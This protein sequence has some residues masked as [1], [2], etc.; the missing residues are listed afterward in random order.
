MKSYTELNIKS[1]YES[2]I[3]NI[4]EDFYEPVLS[5]SISYDR[6]AGFFS[7][8]SLALVAQGMGEF[9]CNGGKM[10]L[11]CSPVLSAQDAK[12]IKDII[13]SGKDLTNEIS[14]DIDI[15]S[16]SFEKD[17]VKALGWMLSRG[18]LEIRLAILT[19]EKG[20]VESTEE[21]LKN[22]L[23][24]QKVGILSDNFGNTLSFSGSINESASAWGKNDEEFKV[25]KSWNSTKE[26]LIKD[27]NK[28][29]EYWNSKRK[30]V[31]LFTLPKALKD[32][33]IIFAKDFEPTSIIRKK[34]RL[35]KFE[36]SIPL[37]HYQNTALVQWKKNGFS[38]LFEM[39]TGTGKTRTALAGIDYL[40]GL[41]K[42]IITVISTPQSTLSLQ[43]KSELEKL[44]IEGGEIVI[45]D[46]NNPKWFMQLQKLLLRQQIGMTDK[47][48]IYTTHDTSSSERFTKLIQQY[49]KK[50]NINLFIGDEAHWLGAPSLQKALLPKY[51]YR[52]GLSA[53]PSRWFD[54]D[55]TSL[56]VNYFG[57]K[58]FEF[59]I[60]QALTE[61]NPL[62]KKHF[63]VNYYYYI[64]KVPLSS[65]ETWKYKNETKKIISLKSRTKHDEKA[66]ENYQRAL[67][68]RAKIIKNAESKYQELKKI[69]RDIIDKGKMENLI[70]FVSPEQL[71]KVSDILLNLNIPF[72]KLTQSEGT[73]PKEKYGFISE[74]E[75]IIK[76]F[77]EKL[78]KALIA[79]KC[80][81]EGIDIP[82]AS[83]G[84]L[85]ASNTNPR[86]YIQRIGRIIRQSEDKE[87]AYLYDLCV[88]TSLDYD[89]E[90]GEFEQ[91]IRNKEKIRMKEIAKNAI[92][93]A[94]ALINIL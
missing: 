60:E 37:F 46:G 13:E 16:N 36:T 47:I 65:E 85:M 94:E 31:K 91:A 49:L 12:I 81:D 59:T 86:E 42:N 52:I 3:D 9:L 87:C 64:H 68:R 26:Y 6:I 45:A 5:C 27:N 18:L 77:K 14:L 43:W 57:N 32:K 72:H 48:T 4:V 55:G 90:I 20:N 30:N 15:I 21:V 66:E 22:G 8:T 63:L 19:D 74:R 35:E 28:F 50:D 38:Q 82:T 78:Y 41:N 53:T 93:S 84:I 58:S 40:L 11:I 39:A 73:Q 56:L 24:H 23:F 17:H 61:I 89:S 88:T 67:E 29:E 69:L 10:R 80:L 51:N 1:C 83:I 25:F 2:G 33:L 34:Q 76:N 44:G 75:Y 54:D 71:E 62:T 79:I 70:I 7:S 92:N